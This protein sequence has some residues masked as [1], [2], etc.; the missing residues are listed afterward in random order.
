MLICRFSD[1]YLL[2]PCFIM[3]AALN[4]P[5]IIRAL[6]ITILFVIL[7]SCSGYIGR[8]INRIFIWIIIFVLFIS[9]IVSF[10]KGIIIIVKN[11]NNLS[12]SFFLPGLIYILVPILGSFIDLEKLKSK[13]VLRGCY[14]GTQNQAYILF[15]ENHTFELNWTGVFFYDEWFTGKWNKKGDT[16]IMKY[17]NKIVSQLGDKVIIRNGYF[18][19]VGNLSDTVK[20]PRPMF[21]VGY[22]K[23]EN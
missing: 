21:Y 15:R 17:D 4:K 8:Y 20:L 19:P 6:V 14:E 1:C 23:G 11:R 10:V 13:V 3:K 12:F 9:M 2:L 18:K 7:I 16:I 5:A 22:C